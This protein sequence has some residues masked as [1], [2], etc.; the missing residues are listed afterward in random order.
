MTERLNGKK[1][2]ESYFVTEPITHVVLEEDYDGAA[3]I[4]DHKGWAYMDKFAVN[5]NVE[6]NG[7]GSKIFS[8]LLKLKNAG[9]FSKKSGLFWRCKIDND[10][11]EMYRKKIEENNESGCYCSEP[12]IVFWIGGPKDELHDIIDYALNKKETLVAK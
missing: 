4:E 6:G 9:N 11:K 5:K 2:I 8:E 3:I 7:L 12:F 10:K 1:L